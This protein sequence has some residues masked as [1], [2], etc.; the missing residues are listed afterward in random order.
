MEP[1]KQSFTQLDL[2]KYLYAELDE[3]TS[4]ALT[5]WILCNKE[6]LNAFEELA[7][8]KKLLGEERYSP[9]ERSIQKILGY[10]ERLALDAHR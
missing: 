10:S 9:S 1:M 3:S 4:L 5:E 7:E 2:I 6:V 8:S